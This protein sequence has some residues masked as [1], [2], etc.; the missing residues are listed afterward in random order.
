[1]AQA[2]LQWRA[3]V[4]G[5]RHY[6]L[7]AAQDEGP[8]G[9]ARLPRPDPGD[10]FFDMEGD[11]L[12][13]GGLEYLFGLYVIDD[14]AERFVPF[15]AHDRRQ[16]KQ[17][18]EAFMDFVAERLRRHPDAHI[19][20]Y[21]PYEA[22]ALKKLMSLHGT[23]EAE[24]DHLLR[25]GKL[26]DLYRVVREGLRISEPSY[27]IKYVERFYLPRR[28][29]EVTNAGASIV[30]YERWKA[31]DEPRLLQDIADYNRDDVIST[32]RLRDW[33]CGIRPAALPWHNEAGQQDLDA[34]RAVIG[35]MTEAERRLLPYRAALADD[36][37]ADEAAWSPRDAFRALAWHL[38]DFH[39]REQKPAWWAWFA[40]AEATDGELIE[41]AECLGGLARD[42]AAPPVRQAQSLRY[43]YRYPAQETKLRTGARCTDVRT[44][45]SLANLVV[46][47]HARLA[48]FTCSAR[49]P[50]P[51][52]PDG[53][54]MPMRAVDALLRREPP[55]IRG[56]A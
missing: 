42:D 5:A 18:F 4:D 45:A 22:T 52:A 10:M 36:L 54:S 43:T 55:R 3:R 49:K 25:A 7:L 15:W 2:A 37:P 34:A 53:M 16:E 21:A 19:Y 17:A 6:E 8:R 9:L 44:G 47:P 46:D 41:D 35:E 11:P 23:R 38:L 33:L 24:V 20:H 50:A 32:W 30:Y 39:R 40:R 29:G 27:S 14:G 48:S 1:R 12:E 13:D 28:A 31:T 26:V 56:L 51:R